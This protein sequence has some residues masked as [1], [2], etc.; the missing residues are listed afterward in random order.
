MQILKYSANGCTAKEIA[1][2]LGLE[3]RTIEIY[4]GNI[5]KKLE[6]KNIAHA[7]FI[8]SRSNILSDVK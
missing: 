7:V 1:R 2:F 6:A 8:A 4:V 3:H 5:R